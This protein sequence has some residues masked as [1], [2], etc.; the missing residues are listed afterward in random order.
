MRICIVGAGAVG[1]Y[2]G[3]KLAL[4]GEEVALVA[5]G[6]HLRAIRERG[7]TLVEADGAQRTATPALATDDIGAAGPQ[8]AVIVAVKAHSLPELAPA[9]RPLYGPETM[10]V[11]AQNGIPWWY[12]LR[13]GGEHE[14]RRVEA[15]DPGGAI[16]ASIAIERVVGCV[17]YPATELAAPG[18][19]RH[20]EGD[21]FTLGEPGGERSPRVQALA[22]ALV[23][24][25]LKAPVRPRIRADIWVKL[26]GNLAFNPISA[27]ARATL[28]DICRHPQARALARAMMLEAQQVAERLGVTLGLTV[29]QRIAGAEQVGAHK[30]SMLQDIEAGRPTEIE[31]LVG[32]VVELARLTGVPTPHI[33]SVYAA[34][35][36]L[37]Q[38]VTR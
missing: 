24:A 31:A 3:A 14:G 1:G 32:A 38:G 35:K 18:V 4:A 13:H 8:D 33:D 15:V 6:A 12:F 21:R 20:I 10:V 36:L 5:R 16:A 9:L 34:V 26:W 28:A 2:L 27:L 30:T 11:T 7:L 22:A 25:G 23:R 17:V 19:V 29:E 37:E